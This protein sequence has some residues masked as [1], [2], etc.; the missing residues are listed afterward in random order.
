M[1]QPSFG[2]ADDPVSKA[3]RRVYRVRP[4]KNSGLFTDSVLKFTVKTMWARVT[5]PRAVDFYLAVARQFVG[6]ALLILATMAAIA[7]WVLSQLASLGLIS[8]GTGKQALWKVGKGADR[9][10]RGLGKAGRGLGTG[11]KQGVGSVGDGVGSVRRG[12]SR[13][14]RTVVSG[15][16]NGVA[17]GLSRSV[18]TAGK[19][20]GIVG[21]GVGRAGRGMGAGISR[22]ASRLSRLLSMAQN[23]ARASAR[24]VDSG[25]RWLWSLQRRIGMRA[26]R[27][28]HWLATRSV[29]GLH[30]YRYATVSLSLSLIILLTSPL[31]S[32]M[33]DGLMQGTRV[34]IASL[35][36]PSLP[37]IQVP[38]VSFPEVS[39]PKVTFHKPR[40]PKLAVPELRVPSVDVPDISI[41]FPAFVTVP[42]KRLDE[43]LTGPL[44]KPGDRVLVADFT[45]DGDS[46]SNLGR[47]LSL[48]LE[49]ELAPA[50]RFTVLPRERA[51]AAVPS[52]AR[53]DAFTLGVE[54]AIALAPAT[55]SAAI[56]TGRYEITDGAYSLDLLILSTSGEEI[57]SIRSLGPEAGLLEAVIQNAG[58]LSRRLGEPVEESAEPSLTAPALSTSL[59]ALIA[60]SAA[61]AQLWRGRYRATIASAAAATRHDTAFAAAHLLAAKSY[62]LVGERWRAKQALESAWQDRGRLPERE[63]LRLAADRE[64]FA[65]RYAN[66]IAGYDRLFGLYRDDV[67]ALKSQAILQRMIGARG[68][69]TGN[70]R[71]AYSIDPI[72][73]PPLRQVARFL[74]YRGRLPSVEQLAEA[75]QATSGARPSI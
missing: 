7:V 62:A 19:S 18:T 10:G 75:P 31:T 29:L 46:A 49:A 20:A 65:G 70:L 1:V 6:L 50:R 59:P 36:E 39:I 40:L 21:R 45:G 30:R 71:V 17:N 73:W 74:G 61:R 37:N 72:D 54:R 5:T 8:F 28:S 12:V 68:R 33:L 13:A 48:V 23:G 43:I 16:S 11:V 56:V 15:A 27:V 42:I 3:A 25:I 60:Y 26:W 22:S 52:P 53:G 24:Q 2:H 58:R 38:S 14:G 9:V 55:A 69:G 64:V 63:R 41:Q 34:R 47:V 35:P 44:A 57:Y 32:A 66:A 67:M 4:A 51:L